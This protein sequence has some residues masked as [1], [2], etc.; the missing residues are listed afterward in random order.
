MVR[1]FFAGI[2]SRMDIAEKYIEDGL[3]SYFYRDSLPNDFWERVDTFDKLMVDSGAY[4]YFSAHGEGFAERSDIDK[5]P[6]EYVREYCEW[7][8]EHEDKIDHYVEMDVAKIV[9]FDKVQKFR[10]IFDSYDLNPMYVYHP[11]N[12]ETWEE[13][14]KEHDMLGVGSGKQD[15]GY[16]V[17]RLKIAENHN[18]DCHLFGFTP[19]QSNQLHMLNKFDSL[20][21]VDSTSWTAG[22][23][24]GLFYYFDRS[25]GQLKSVG[26]EKFHEKY[27][28]AFN[29]LPSEDIQK[30]NVIHW[31]E[32]AKYMKKHE[33]PD[34]T[35][36]KE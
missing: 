28:K 21:S 29:E 11:C 18:V 32:Y 23:R 12:D 34:E 33:S 26:N 7:L 35:K 36:V 25:K 31:S 10:Q 24:F 30:H 20:Y 22:T 27:G 8:T 15:F 9:G 6:E 3:F 19:T 2:S 16:V 4:S 17:N 13:L 5:D 14:C 1:I